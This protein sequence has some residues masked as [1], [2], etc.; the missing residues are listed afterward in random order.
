MGVI[1][2]VGGNQGQDT[3]KFLEK[4]RLVYCFEPIPYLANLL[5][6]KYGKL[7]NFHLM[8]FAIDLENGFKKFN[9]DNRADWGCSSLHDVAVDNPNG[10][11]YEDYIHNVMCMRLDTFMDLYEIEEIDYLHIDAQGNDYRVL[12]SLGDKIESVKEGVVEVS[13]KSKYYSVDDN[14][15]E[16][17]KPWLE[18]HGF[19]VKVED[20]GV[21]KEFATITG[22]EAN[23]F[24]KRMEWKQ[25]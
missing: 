22:N 7:P 3:E 19:S 14:T 25:E 11:C 6:E 16:I 12:Q 20:D 4:D 10:I 9:I 1:I 23:L 15:V 18:S 8:S 13:Q 5:S 17:V 24:F 2:E 21:G